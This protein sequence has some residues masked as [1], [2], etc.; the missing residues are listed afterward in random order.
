MYLLFV[1]GQQI[2][3]EAIQT[4]IERLKLDPNLRALGEESQK[5]CYLR[6]AAEHSLIGRTLVEQKAYSDPRPVDPELI[7]REVGRQ[8]ALGASGPAFDD[9][10]LRAGIET[11]MRVQR[12]LADL[13]A[14]AKRPT[15]DDLRAFYAEHSHNFRSPV[16]FH[17]AHIV[18][19][20]NEHQTEDQARA[21]IQAALLELENGGSF[22]EVAERWSDC[23][24]SGGDLGSFPGGRMVKEFEDVLRDLN[25]GDRSGIFVTPFGFHIVELRAKQAEGVA[26]FDS[27]R[28]DLAR[29]MNTMAEHQAFI[30]AVEELRRKA[31]IRKVD[32]E[33]RADSGKPMKSP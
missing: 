4:E 12:T 20:V 9:T 15:A 30:T 3:E 8:G 7:S 17:A 32:V 13:V 16:L 11:Q 19:H 1:N 28:N 31:D 25:V 22:T 23:K 26:D 33:R 6:E 29:V 2:T 27:V 5:A 24:G 14:A 18:R 21:A 10:C